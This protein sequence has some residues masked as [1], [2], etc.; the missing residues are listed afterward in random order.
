MSDNSQYWDLYTLQHKVKEGVSSIFPGPVWVRAEIASIGARQNG[1]CYLE[2]SQSD[3]RGIIAK[4]RA[5]IWRSSYTFIESYFRKVT[6]TALSQGM[7]I[8]VRAQVTFHEIYG[9]SLVIDD[10]DPDFTLGERERRRRETIERLQKEGLMDLQ[11]ELC[12]PPAPYYLA[13]IT[14]ETA[15]GFGDFRR[16]LM[17]NE[18][19]FKYETDLFPAIMQGQDAPSSIVGAMDA[20]LSSGKHYDAVLIL[21]GGGS[22]LD[23]ACYDE[24]ELAEAIARCPVPVFTA[25]GH[26]RDFHVAD[27]VANTY[28]KTPTALA[29]LFIECTAAEDERISAFEQR[30]SLAFTG[31]MSSMSSSLDS[32]GARIS[33]AVRMRLEGETGN[34]SSMGMRIVHVS[35]MRL[36]GE[37]AGL[38]SLW[39][40]ISHGVSMRVE[41]ESSRLDL[42]ETRL[43]SS[44]PRNVLKRG[45]SLVLDSKGV[46]FSSVQGRS[47]GEEIRVVMPDGSLKCEINGIK[48]GDKGE[49]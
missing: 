34:I 35:R 41:K 6:G 45:F 26:D 28:V 11:K 21:R 43:S 40:R 5:V 15:A 25:I 29:D 27:M 48:Y 16:H 3:S 22:D 38:D 2:L 36:E 20:A 17:E 18:Y 1:H 24:Y 13:V 30:L 12:L 4:A 46:R 44:D 39:M 23:L 47:P 14:S 31:R 33:H 37:G 10:I 9:Y 42:L 7:K 19:G 8:L 32:L 49:I